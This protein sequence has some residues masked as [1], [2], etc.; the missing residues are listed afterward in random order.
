MELN[1]LLHNDESKD[2]ISMYTV[3]ILI[4][5]SSI[6]P[7]ADLQGY[8]LPQLLDIQAYYETNLSTD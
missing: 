5:A 1:E 6:D 8:T 7:S 4:H 2:L 3:N